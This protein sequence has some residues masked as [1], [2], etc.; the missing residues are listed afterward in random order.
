MPLALA[1]RV[2]M[3]TSLHFQG[4]IDEAIDVADWAVSREPEDLAAAAEGF[5][6]SPYTYILGLR[7]LLF[8][9]KGRFQEG[10]RDLDR[11]LGLANAGADAEALGC[12]HGF[13][14][15]HARCAGDTVKAHAH[16]HQMVEVAERTGIPLLRVDAYLALGCAHAL[17]ARWD[18]ALAALERAL[19]IVEARRILIG[20]RRRILAG[21][22]E[23]YLGRGETER[24]RHLAEELLASP[25][26]SRALLVELQ[27]QLVVAR[28]LLR[29]E[30]AQARGAGRAALCEAHTS[31]WLA[32]P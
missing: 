27:A 29:A 4:R 5:G 10:A 23:A 9:L 20:Q 12:V 24:A 16:A 15:Q 19:E 17:S 1:A 26:G 2:V 14:V 21:L 7:G 11:A 13:S 6:I 3:A 28:A 8:A 31:V 22:A 18:E 32:V 25:R 30:G